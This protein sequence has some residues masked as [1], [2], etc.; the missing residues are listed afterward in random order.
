MILNFKFYQ[1]ILSKWKMFNQMFNGNI[2]FLHFQ[3]NKEYIN[4]IDF[5]FLYVYITQKIFSKT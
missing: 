4:Y 1:K 3:K 5:I 2:I